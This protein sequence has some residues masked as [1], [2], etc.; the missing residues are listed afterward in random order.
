MHKTFVRRKRDALC[1]NGEDKEAVT[2]VEPCTCS[3]MDY[4]CD[5]GYARKDGQTAC[6]EQ[7]TRQTDSEKQQAQQELYAEQ[8]MEYGY[9]EVTQGYRKVPGNICTGGVD[10]NPYR[11]QCSTS[12][13][14]ASFFTFRSLIMVAVLSAICYYGWPVIEAVLLLLPIPDPSELKTKA[15]EY[16]SK[17]VELVKSVP[18]MVSGDDAAR[19]PAP[20]Y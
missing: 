4:E 13:W 1:Y 17:A 20:G 19:A 11:Y 5:I 6:L 16:G 2:H 3:E 12:G 15:Q 8:C 18:A 7:E 14:I 10:L 9:Y